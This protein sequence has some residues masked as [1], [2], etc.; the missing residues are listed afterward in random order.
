MRSVMDMEYKYG[1]MELNMKVS[2]FITK[3]RVAE[4]FGTLRVMYTMVSSETTRLT[5]MEHTLI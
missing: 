1:Q 4:H 5:A 2:G 3:L